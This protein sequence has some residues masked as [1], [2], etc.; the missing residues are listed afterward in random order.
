VEQRH[1][2]YLLGIEGL[3][4]LRARGPLDERVRDMRELLAAFDDEPRSLPSVDVGAGYAGWAESYDEP[5]NDTV[6]A[7]EPV[8]RA[9]LDELPLDGPVL[10]A[11]C[12]TGRHAAY[13]AAAG[14]EVVGVDASEA[15]LARARAKLPDVDFRTGELESLPVADGSM[16]GAVCAL[17]LSHVAD[18]KPAIA[19]LARVLKPGGRLVVSNP[20]PFATGVLGWRAVYTDPAS[21]ERTE[22]PEYA[23]LAADYVD[24]FKAAGL[25]VRRLIEPT[26][27]ADAARARAKRGY[28]E[29]F[30][31]ALTGIPFLIVWEVASPYPRAARCDSSSASIAL[32]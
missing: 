26:L 2:D 21:G 9:L 32:A 22:I 24:A 8:V 6:A 5:G 23:H 31:D 17:A 30:A 27:S 20:H 4:L 15:M 16:A 11:A 28:A 12:G 1:G 13:L 18:M 7:E 29:A 3:A 10:D 25:T 14:R 19:E